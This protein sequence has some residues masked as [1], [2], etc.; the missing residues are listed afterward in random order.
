MYR[1]YVIP[2]G[3]PVSMDTYHM[4]TNAALFPKPDEFR[5]ERWAGDPRV[6]AAQLEAAGYLAPL[7]GRDV[8]LSHFLTS[9]SRGT[10]MCAGI[11][12]A[13][14]EIYIG[15][16]TLFRRHELRLFETDRRDVDFAIDMVTPQ[17]V[18]DSKGIRVL[19]EK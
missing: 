10:R 12:I 4:H 17:P 16:A 3:V 15:L 8:P 9:F 6:S 19:V 2:P 7:S 18:R 1:N 13:Y 5:P 11:N 14:A